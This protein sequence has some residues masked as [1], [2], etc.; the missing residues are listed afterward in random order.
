MAE[1]VFTNG[2][3]LFEGQD[4]TGQSN[5]I[6]VDF[7][8]EPL[9]RTALNDTTRRRVGG[10]KIAAISASGF[11]GAAEPDATLFANVGTDDQIITVAP[12]TVEGDPSFFMRSI[13][14]ELTPLGGE[15]GSLADFSLA[16]AANIGD[17]I[18]GFIGQN[19]TQTV[20]GNA[21]GQ[22]LGAIAATQRLF[23]ATHI[24]AVAGAAPSLQVI[25]QSDD[26]AGFTTP[27]DRITFAAASAI[28]SQ[29]ASLPGLIADD[30]W[31]V[32]FVISGTAPSFTFIISFGIQ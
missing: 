28:G 10:L 8:A 20:T 7:S 32:R 30:F 23:V 21:T 29:F 11:F 1:R 5:Q 18:R 17:L 12:T 31:R 19:G 6:A 13:V 4:L 9:D 24:T 3:I 26:N 16:A 14:S 22:Q 15:V 2:L 25:I 27:T